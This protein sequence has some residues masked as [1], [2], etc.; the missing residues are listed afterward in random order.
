MTKKHIAISGNIG[1]GKTTL[2]G[3]LSK[4]F[5]WEPEYESVDQNPYLADF[6]QDMPRWAFHLQIYFLNSRFNQLKRIKSSEV[7]VIQDRTIYEDANI[8]ALNLYESGHINDR[9]YEN[10]L[11]V[12]ESMMDFVQPPDLMIYLRADVPK[13]IERIQQRGRTFEF[14]M[15]LEYLQDL[16]EHYESW[17]RQ[18]DLGQKMFIDV[19]ELDFVNRIEDFADV[20]ERVD[21]QLFGLFSE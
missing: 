13:L 20:V 15:R 12:Y 1:T 3:K 17:I 6:Y 14:A 19:N 8:F 10:Y 7:T 18:Y 5:G 21:A 16:N 9:D 4:H 2:A 11:N